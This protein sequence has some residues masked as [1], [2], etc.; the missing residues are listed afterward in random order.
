MDYEMLKPISDDVLVIKN[1]PTTIATLDQNIMIKQIF[2]ELGITFESSV[3]IN[4]SDMPYQKV[5]VRSERN[6]ITLKFYNG[7][8]Q[9]FDKEPLESYNEDGDSGEYFGQESDEVFE[10]E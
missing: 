2:L 4:I 5:V 7:I 1:G 3:V 8:L 9:G 6:K 10:F